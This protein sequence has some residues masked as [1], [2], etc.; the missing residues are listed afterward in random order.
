MD[1]VIVLLS[2]LSQV[3]LIGHLVFILNQV[4]FVNE[5]IINIR[6]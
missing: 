6:G 4:V 5:I 3:M 2:R 1:V